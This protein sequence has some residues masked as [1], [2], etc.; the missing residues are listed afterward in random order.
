MQVFNRYIVKNLLLATTFITVTLSAVIILTQSLRFLELI[1]ESG[2]DTQTFWTLTLL[3]LPR[4]W[5]VIVPIALMIATTFTYSRLKDS[6]ELVIMRGTG[7]SPLKIAR[8]A[9]MI[10]VFFTLILWGITLWGTPHSLS[11]LQKIKHV[12]QSQFS[13][14]LLHENVFN[15]LGK[16]FI[17][18]VQ[19]RDSSGT[20]S[21][22]VIHDQ[23]ARDPY[24]STILAKRGVLNE[25]DGAY[26]VIVY[27]GSRQSYN[28]ETKILQ[29]LDFERYIV[30]LPLTSEVQDRWKQPDERTL[31][32]LLNPDPT[33]VRDVEYTQKFKVELHR[34]FTAP[35]LALAF[36]LI[37]ATALVMGPVQ[38][39]QNNW[40]TFFIIMGAILVQGLFIAVYNY[41]KNGPWGFIG[42]YI[43]PLAPIIGCLYLLSPW[44]EISRRRLLYKPER[45]T[46]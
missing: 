30:D 11:Y 46:S 35:L 8:P 28:P 4:F 29:R 23:S 20:L 1:I 42:M 3:A 10:S 33:V 5:E 34:R 22:V 37:A 15:R 2:A 44:G 25:Q 40:R 39:N 7:F 19:D 36:T 18:Y 41:A 12:V 32:E 16:D 38:R 17:V 43:V 9:I 21:G 26:Q 13:V 27:N 6:S 31:T 45:P 24:P 14:M